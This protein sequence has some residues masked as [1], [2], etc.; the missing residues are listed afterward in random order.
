VLDKV[1]DG[2]ARLVE[3]DKE[4]WEAS[5]DAVIRKMGGM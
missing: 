5:V 4:N 3:V 1:A 2:K